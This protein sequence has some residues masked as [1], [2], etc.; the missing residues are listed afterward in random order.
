[1]PDRSATTTQRLARLQ[2]VMD[3]RAVDLVV[4]GPSADFH[5]LAGIKPYLSERLA[6]LV[7][8]RQGR[9]WLVVPKLQVPLYELLAE[10]LDFVVWTETERPTSHVV[11]LAQRVGA[12]VLAVNDDLWSTF[13]L[14]LQ[15]Q[16][17]A[18]TFRSGSEVLAPLRSIKEAGELELL[19]EASRRLDL[20][21][22]EFCATTTLIGATEDQVDR[23]LRDLMA[24]HGTAVLWCDVASGPHGA[25]PLHA[26]GWRT[27]ERGDPITLDFAASYQGYC[28]DMCRTPV[29]GE[30]EAEFKRAYQVVYDAQ[31]EA[32]AA[33]KPGVACQEIDRVG[34]RIIRDAGYGEFFT[35]RIGHG[36]GLAAHEDPYIVEGNATPLEPGMTFSDEPGIYLPGRWGIRIE[37]IVA[38]TPAGA[39]RFNLVSRE[40]VC[41]P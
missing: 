27:I 8:P 6:A 24:A 35:H 41:L 7:V 21:W 5:Y 23:R 26:G 10:Q 9:G 36:I 29:A 37:D 4:V 39:E 3:D 28:A 34:R 20:V 13:L 22:E 30:P 31:Q 14:Q 25:S 32:F 12:R 11:R 18:L 40:L 19:R 17:P 33:I 1:M 16:L 15:E 38:V 2:Q